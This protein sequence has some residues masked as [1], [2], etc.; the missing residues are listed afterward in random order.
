MYRQQF[1][2][3]H[4]KSL[5]FHRFRNHSLLILVEDLLLRDGWELLARYG[6]SKLDK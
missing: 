6:K 4:Y 2:Y 3:I 1:D 5:S